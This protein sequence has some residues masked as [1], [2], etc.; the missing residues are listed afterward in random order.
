MRAVRA[1]LLVLGVV[2]VVGGVAGLIW[3]QPQPQSVTLPDG[4]Q[5]T[6]LKVTQGTN[7]ILRFGRRWQDF[8]YPVLP[9]KLR[10]KYP[11]RV[12]EFAGNR[13]DSVMVWFQREG[14]APADG[15]WP[16]VYLAVLDDYGLESPLLLTPQVA[17]TLG[18]SN[19]AMTGPGGGS[20][21]I[22]RQLAGWEVLDY[23]KR[24]GGFRLRIYGNGAD[25]QL[26]PAGDVRI[27]KLARNSFPVWQAESLPAVRLTNVL[28]I[29]LT[30]LE[31]GAVSPEDGFTPVGMVAR[32]YSRAT[33]RLQENN[34]PAE[35]WSVHRLR[36]ASATGITRHGDGKSARWQAGQHTA[37]A[38]GGLWLE[39]PAWKVQ[40]EFA[41]TADFPAE[42]LWH[43]KAVAVP[44]PGRTTEHRVVTNLHGEELE[45]LGVS[46]FKQRP[47]PVGKTYASLQVRTPHPLDALSVVLVEVRDEQG[48]RAEPRGVTVQTG[49]GGRGITPKETVINFRIEIPEG[50]RL[51]DIALAATPV[52]Q[53]EFLAKPELFAA[54]VKLNHA[55]RVPVSGGD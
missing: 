2:I 40:A 18:A 36:L 17:R 23:P 50:A 21:G 8:L 54:S 14:F 51:L 20:V 46:G 26:T 41:R 44:Q 27:P 31:T 32:V 42:D 48:R 30:Q 53:V 45:F 16:R 13:P 22:A 4:S 37:D 38:W 43:I 35:N 12:M 55:S 33:F 24:S 6:L 49:T 47:G 52:Q 5:F 7:H 11:P 29:T 9:P 10:L 39:E 25:Q 34:L 19:A 3:R 28:E 15:E 1:S